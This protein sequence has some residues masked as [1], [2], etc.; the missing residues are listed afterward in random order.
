MR[1]PSRL[2]GGVLVAT[3]LTQISACGSIFYPDRRGQIDGKVDPAIAALDAFAL[4]FYIVPGVIA[5]AVDFATGAIYYAPGEIDPQKLQK[6]IKADGS[7]DN[8]KL[9]AIIETELGRSLPLNDPR[10]IQHKGS[11][12]QLA[13]LGLVPAA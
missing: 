8:T 6:A 4:L 5:F 9:Q 3:L 13:A 12:E 7:V 1:I 10:L 11:V 2:I